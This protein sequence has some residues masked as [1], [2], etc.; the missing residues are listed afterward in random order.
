MWFFRLLG[1]V[2]GERRHAEGFAV[3]VGLFFETRVLFSG[4]HADAVSGLDADL[5][6]KVWA[7]GDD[8]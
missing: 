7:V 5:G 3:H 6:K 4:M 8:V 2:L 1:S